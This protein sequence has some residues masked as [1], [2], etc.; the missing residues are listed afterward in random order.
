MLNIYAA[1]CPVGR[2]VK[3]SIEIPSEL[4]LT[5]TLVFRGLVDKFLVER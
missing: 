2:P 1:G 3:G 4:G 5:P